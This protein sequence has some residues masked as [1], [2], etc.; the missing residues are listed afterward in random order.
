M[1]TKHVCIITIVTYTC[2]QGP[3]KHKYVLE[4]ILGRHPGRL[5]VGVWGAA[6]A[7]G[8]DVD[9]SE[10]VSSRDI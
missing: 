7:P 5:D 9:Q 3:C 10:G 1:Q 2:L 6:A 8:E 4:S